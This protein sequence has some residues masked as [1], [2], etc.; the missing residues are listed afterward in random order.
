MLEMIRS[1]A[2]R[3]DGWSMRVSHKAAGG[4][5]DVFVS[6]LLLSMQWIILNDALEEDEQMREERKRTREDDG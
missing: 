2:D 6:E 5:I 1:D 3:D 4:L